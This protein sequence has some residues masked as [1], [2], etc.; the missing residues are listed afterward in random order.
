V[1]DFYI[2]LDIEYYL[3]IEF[4]YNFDAQKFPALDSQ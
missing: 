3:L 4:N 2:I 1:I